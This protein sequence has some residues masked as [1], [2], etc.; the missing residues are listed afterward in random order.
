MTFLLR[1][2]NMI[3]MRR[4]QP[5]R[6]AILSPSSRT[7]QPCSIINIR[8]FEAA[9]ESPY[10]RELHTL[11]VTAKVGDLYS[12]NTAAT[13]I[14][15]AAN[16]PLLKAD[17]NIVGIFFPTL[18]WMIEVDDVANGVEHTLKFSG[19]VSSFARNLA[20][21][22]YVS[23]FS[24]ELRPFLR[25]VVAI[26][27]NTPNLVILTVMNAQIEDVYDVLDFDV[28]FEPVGFAADGIDRGFFDFIGDAIGFIVKPI[29]EIGGKVIKFI[30]DQ[31]QGF[32]EN[33]IETAKLVAG[34]VIRE[35]FS[36]VDIDR[37]LDV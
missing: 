34:G 19:D 7:L 33:V 20:P 2:V 14:V 37:P 15:V 22:D 16:S 8:V 9:I 26:V 21:G 12:N 10:S 29:V 3:S 4:S 27:E 28:G 11:L 6:L 17:I 35:E 30:G 23:G 13:K 32:V 5:C 31:V 24:S 1:W 25:L 36:L 18:R